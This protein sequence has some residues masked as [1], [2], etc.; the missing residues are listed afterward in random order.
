MDVITVSRL[1]GR[2]KEQLEVWQ[3]RSLNEKVI[4]YLYLDGFGDTIQAGDRVVRIKTKSSLP[5]VEAVLILLYG[6]LPAVRL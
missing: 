5:S 1:V 2:L 4:F 6:L 3:S